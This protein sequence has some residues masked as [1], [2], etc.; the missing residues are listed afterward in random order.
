MSNVQDE[1]DMTDE[2]KMVIARSYM[3]A[4]R[5]SLYPW[6]FERGIQPFR[7]VEDPPP[8]QT[9]EESK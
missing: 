5:R 8:Q 2:E 4:N 3:R 9:E 1:D 6:W 7:E